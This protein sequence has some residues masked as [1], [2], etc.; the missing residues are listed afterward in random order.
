MN[1]HLIS[2]RPRL[3]KCVRCGALVLTGLS[4]GAWAGVNT[5]PL[6]PEELRALLV[7][8]GRPFRM[9]ELAGRAQELRPASLGEIRSGTSLLGAHTCGAHPMDARSVEELPQVPLQPPANA[10]G[11]PAS[12]YASAPRR[13][14]QNR[15][16]A[17][18][19]T[20]H[21]SRPLKCDTCRAPITP[22]EAYWGIECGQYLWAV[23][24][25]CPEVGSN[26]KR[27]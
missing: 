7:A 6:S 20:P 13:G 22:G 3:G 23:H 19:A 26:D 18:P 25:A 9:V 12:P 16:A 10:T 5:S 15:S 14:T 21:L 4:G 11:R 24:D 8:G 2:T 17:T 1:Q 27:P